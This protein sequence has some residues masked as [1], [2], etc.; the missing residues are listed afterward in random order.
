MLFVYLFEFCFCLLLSFIYLFI[1]LLIVCLFLLCEAARWVYVYLFI[2]NNEKR[3]SIADILDKPHRGDVITM[4]CA[5][6]I[7]FEQ[8]DAIAN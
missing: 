2:S 1:Y 3:L 8:E 5:S 6:R 7:G 4:E